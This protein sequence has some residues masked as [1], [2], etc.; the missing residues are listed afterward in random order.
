[1][2]EVVFNSKLTDNGT[3]Y[4]PKEYTFGNADYKVIVSV[5]EDNDITSEAEL[6]AINDNSADFLSDQEIQYYLNLEEK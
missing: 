4:C 5:P 6:S 2:Y 1:M 3:L